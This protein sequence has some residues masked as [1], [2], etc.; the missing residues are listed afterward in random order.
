LHVLPHDRVADVEGNE[1]L[2]AIAQDFAD[3]IIDGN[4]QSIQMDV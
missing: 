1:E 3:F 2:R 4:L